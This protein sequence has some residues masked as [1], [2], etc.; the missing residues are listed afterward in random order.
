MDKQVD[1]VVVARIHAVHLDIDHMGYPRHRMPIALMARCKCPYNG[2]HCKSAA[3]V[4]IFIDVSIVIEIYKI[5]S[6]DL[7]EYDKGDEGQKET[8]PY[9]GADTTGLR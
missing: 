7:Q 4:R 2:I 1:L 3:D 9:F 5:M 6:A 8:N